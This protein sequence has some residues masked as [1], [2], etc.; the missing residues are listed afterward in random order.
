[1]YMKSKSKDT[2]TSD[3]IIGLFYGVITPMLNT[4]I[5]SLR[6]KEV[7]EAVKKNLSRHLHSWKYK[8]A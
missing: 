2:K 8:S 7:K 6:N 5:Y 4:I 3:E 1:M